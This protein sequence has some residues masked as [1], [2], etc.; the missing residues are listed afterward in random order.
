LNIFPAAP[1][2]FVA[3]RDTAA[4][5]GVYYVP[6][7]GWAH[8]QANLAFP[9]LPMAF[10]GLTHGK[11]V[12]TPD[13]YVTDSIHGQCFDKIDDWIA[14]IDRAKRKGEDAE[15]DGVA[16]AAKD[17][18]PTKPAAAKTAPS[19]VIVFGTKTYQSKS[20]WSYPEQNAVFELEGGVP[21]PKDE[22]VTKVTREQFAALKKAGAT[23]IDPSGQVSEDPA[24]EDE[25]DDGGLV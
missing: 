13:G 12:V 24:E 15:P 9:I 17:P 21:Y 7:I 14:F 6:V 16:T 19:G 22:R 4:N 10:G 2:T 11:C 5:H 23:K 8:V 25:N 1:G 20:F 18:A 3:T